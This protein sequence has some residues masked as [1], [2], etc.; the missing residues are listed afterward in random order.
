[1]SVQPV[2]PRTRVAFFG[3]HPHQQNGYSKVVYELAHAMAARHSTDIELHIF[4]FQH[5]YNHPA[6]RIEMPPGVEIFDAF[7]AE[8]PKAQ[9]FGFTEARAYVERVQPDVVV[10]FNDLVVL[11]NMLH[12][13]KDA[14]NRKAFKLVAYIDQVYLCQRRE[15]LE[16]VNQLADAAIAFTPEWQKCIEWQGLR[17]PSHVLAHGINPRSHFP[18]PRALARKFWGVSDTDFLVLNLNRN[19]PRKRWDTCLQ[20]FAEVVARRPT[21]PIRLV[22]GTETRGAWDLMQLFERELRKRGVTDLAAGMARVVIPGHPQMLS[23]D[24]TNILYNIADVGI[25]TC[26]GEGF[27]LCNF[28][29]AALGIPQIVPRLGGFLHFFDDATAT[30]VD[31]VTSIYVDATRD[32]IGG[33]AELTHWRD[34]ADAILRYYDDPALRLKHGQAA[35]AS[36]LARFPWSRIADE[37]AAIVHAT[38]PPR[39]APAAPLPLL[40]PPT[41]ASASASSA[42]EIDA[43][44]EIL[45]D[46]EGMG[47]E[48][49]AASDAAAAA[50]ALRREVDELR[51]KLAAL[52]AHAEL[53]ARSS[54]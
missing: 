24:E 12:Q 20:A 51:Q 32:G 14:S 42:A 11:T 7:A 47:E 6:H 46:V 44:A 36:I 23:D 31:P 13:L 39:P 16:I 35:R 28:E 54:S 34:Y 43:A 53:V 38:F 9:G 21:A 45:G 18:V 8:E 10:I 1:M 41:S 17:L 3:T 40:S 26:D 33:E 30:L 49:A 25:N 4:G 50:A 5:F 2:R 48:V 19:Q 27:G 29:Q 37:F 15:L 22:V 52:T